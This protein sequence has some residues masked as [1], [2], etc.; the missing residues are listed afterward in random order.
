MEFLLQ[1][2]YWIQNPGQQ[3]EQTYKNPEITKVLSTYKNLYWH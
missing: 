3:L 1:F 2:E